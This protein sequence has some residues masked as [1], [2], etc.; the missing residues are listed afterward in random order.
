MLMVG[1]LGDE[2]RR[3]LVAVLLLQ[4]KRTTGAGLRI[5]RA[6]VAGFAEETAWVMRACDR[7]QYRADAY[8][9]GCEGTDERWWFWILGF[10]ICSG[11]AGLDGLAVSD[12]GAIEESCGFVCNG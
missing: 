10:S 6:S 7:R 12:G 2:V 9:R 3:G 1:L 8:L 4:V 11:E 5:D